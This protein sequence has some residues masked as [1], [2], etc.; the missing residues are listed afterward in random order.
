MTLEHNTEH[1]AQGLSAL[2]YDLR[3]P[4]LQALATSYLTEVQELED[5]LWSLYLGTMIG[6]AFGASL[7]E[8]GALVGQAREGRGDAVYR[9]WILARVIVLRSSGRPGDL[10]RIANAVLPATVKVVLVEEYPAALTIRLEGVIDA[11]LGAAVAQLLQLAKAD[12]VRLIVTY[13]TTTPFRYPADGI[14]ESS[15][16]SGYGAG[17]YASIG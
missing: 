8:I 17:G 3:Q 16:L 1:V 7:D 6:G 2:I 10:T 4:K 15:S 14:D 11:A 9:A 13:Q 12:G 5:A